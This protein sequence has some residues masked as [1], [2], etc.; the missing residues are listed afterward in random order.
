MA[1]LL[2]IILCAGIGFFT[3]GIVGLV[4]GAVV[5][6]LLS[7][8]IGLATAAWS[9]GFLPRKA[10]KQV[11]LFFY[12]NHQPTVDSRLVGM[13][14]EEKLRLI[15]NL[16]ERIFRR[17]TVAAPLVS[18]SMGM[19]PPEITEAA[20]QE[21]AEEENPKVRELIPLLRDHILQTMY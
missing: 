15:E 2:T 16:M 10:R 21:A 8:L 14:E 1:P 12:M 6:W 19:S 3:H 11:A 7:M 20:R 5:G 17:A 4:A 18:E 13:T 9:G